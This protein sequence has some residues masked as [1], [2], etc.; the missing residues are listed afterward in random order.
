[1]TTAREMDNEIDW[2]SLTFDY[3]PADINLRCHYSDGKWGEIEATR[4]QEVELPIASTCLH[5]GQ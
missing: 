1:M 2:S 4:S 3:T 5:Y